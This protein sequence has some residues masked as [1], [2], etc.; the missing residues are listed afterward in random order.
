MKRMEKLE[1]ISYGRFSSEKQE[2]GD[3]IERQKRAFNGVLARYSERLFP[4]SRFTFFDPGL[5]GFHSANLKNGGDLAR[6]LDGNA[7][8]HGDALPHSGPGRRLD[9]TVVQSL[10]RH[11]A[12][13]QLALEHVV[14]RLQL[15]LIG[16]GK[17]QRVLAIHLDV[18]LRVLQVI[19]GVDFLQ[20][21]LNGIGD[22]LQVH[23]AYDVETILSHKL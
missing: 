2:K 6:F 11:V 21:L 14:D 10:Q 18:R 16:R 19:S 9:S 23:L 12:L 3:S 7:L 22:L 15:E 4:S 20:C 17:H 1:A 8:L 5:S 13:H